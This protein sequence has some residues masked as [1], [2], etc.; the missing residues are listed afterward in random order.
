MLVFGA[1]LASSSVGTG[2]SSPWHKAAG[3]WNWPLSSIE[4][5]GSKWVELDCVWNVMA[6]AQKPDFVIRRNGRVHLNRKGGS[7]HSTT[8]SRG[9]RISGSNA[10][11]TKFRGSVKGTVYPLHS[12][13][14]PSLPLPCV[15]VCHRAIT[16]QLDSHLSSPPYAF[17]AG[18]G[19]LLISKKWTEFKIR[20]WLSWQDVV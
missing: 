13:V 6:H 11:Y 9:V 17:L 7:V 18:T 2:G 14:S 10:G 8:G 20:S 16:F 19:T 3:A 12:P 4:F 1:H 5:R 15:T